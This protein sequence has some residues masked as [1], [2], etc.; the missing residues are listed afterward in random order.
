MVGTF[1]WL[2]H[3]VT[4]WSI[5]QSKSE[6]ERK[7]NCGLMSAKDFISLQNYAVKVGKGPLARDEG[8]CIVTLFYGPDQ[9]AVGYYQNAWYDGW[10]AVRLGDFVNC[11]YPF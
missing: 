5:P 1:L 6:L 8:K 10:A 3:D 7:T 4:L 11:S 2:Q 9:S